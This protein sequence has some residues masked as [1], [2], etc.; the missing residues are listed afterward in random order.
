MGFLSLDS[1]LVQCRLKLRRVG[2]ALTSN[3]FGGNEHTK[4]DA[5]D[6]KNE[7]RHTRDGL[8][9]PLIPI[10]EAVDAMLAFAAAERN[11]AL[12]D[13]AHKATS[14][15]VGD[16]KNGIPLRSPSPHEI[17]AAILALRERR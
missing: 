5:C 3:I 16:P 4:N 7:A 14:F 6:Y 10:G 12:D 9:D 17:R 11:A 13:A 15:L 1:F 2:I 8:L